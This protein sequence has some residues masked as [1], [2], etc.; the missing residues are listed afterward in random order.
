MNSAGSVR[1]NR[2]IK[3]MFGTS[4]KFSRIAGSTGA[5]VAPANMA[6]ELAASRVIRTTVLFGSRVVVI[7][8]S[9]STET[10]MTIVGSMKKVYLFF[11]SVLI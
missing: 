7:C 2:T 10:G 4:P 9:L 1:T 5:S 8:I 3:S 11:R 6:T